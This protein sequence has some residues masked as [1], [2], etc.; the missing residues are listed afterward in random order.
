[1]PQTAD[2]SGNKLTTILGFGEESTDTDG[3]YMLNERQ[4]KRQVDK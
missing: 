3:V 1:M 4:F 2:F